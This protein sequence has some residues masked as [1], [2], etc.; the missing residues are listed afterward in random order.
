MSNGVTLLDWLIRLSLAG[1]L[2]GII[3]FERETRHKAAGLRTHML[4][5]MG[6]ALFTILSGSAFDQGDPSRI[7]AQVVTGVGF[8]GAGAIF[9]SGANVHGL[10]T[11]AGLWAVAAIG[12]AAGAGLELGAL[13]ATALGVVVL[14]ALRVVEHRW[15][16][17]GERRTIGVTTRNLEDVK[18]IISTAHSVDISARRVTIETLEEDRFLVTFSVDREL[19]GPTMA[20]LS[21]YPSVHDVSE[22]DPNGDRS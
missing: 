13:V 5:A 3:G 7:A 1:V 20:A 22:V 9:R 17:S 18:E 19:V 11:A 12:M 16:R 14:V 10:T 15:I 4:V 21:A 2:S 6:A 8:L